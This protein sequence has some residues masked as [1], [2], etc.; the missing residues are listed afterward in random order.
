MAGKPKPG[1]GAEAGKVT[2]H[3]LVKCADVSTV[4]TESSDQDGA[5]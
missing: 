4:M 5:T 3:I 2:E 1:S